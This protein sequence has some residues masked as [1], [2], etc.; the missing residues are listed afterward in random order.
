[1]WVEER[2]CGLTTWLISTVG[3]FPCSYFCPCDRR[4]VWL[5]GGKKVRGEIYSYVRTHIRLR[6]HRNGASSYIPVLGCLPAAM[7]EK[8]KAHSFSFLTASVCIPSSAAKCGVFDRNPSCLCFFL[9][10]GNWACCGVRACVSPSVGGAK[11]GDPKPKL[12]LRSLLLL[13]L[14]LLLFLPTPQ[15]YNAQGAT[16]DDYLFL[17]PFPAGSMCHPNPTR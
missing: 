1:M 4:T 17:N 11:S 3:S 10:A 13:L 12:I 7:R 9:G 5:A 14:L 16:V 8:R 6:N 15:Q 2:Y